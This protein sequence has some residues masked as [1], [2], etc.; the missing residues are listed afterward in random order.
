M[1]LSK[2]TRPSLCWEFTSLLPVR[3]RR[4]LK[5]PKREKDVTSGAGMG[6]G[7]LDSRVN[8]GQKRL[9]SVINWASGNTENQFHLFIYIFRASWG[10][11]WELSL[12]ELLDL[13]TWRDI[14]GRHRSLQRHRQ[15]G[16][17]RHPHEKPSHGSKLTPEG[18][19]KYS[20]GRQQHLQN[21]SK[22]P[23]S[24][25]PSPPRY[26]HDAKYNPWERDGINSW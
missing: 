16:A 5:G 22:S 25:C 15:E 6:S 13:W 9:Y 14:K 18:D 3:I 2:E 12:V 7:C 20:P 10:S 21:G 1:P 8:R 4:L 23:V 17:G 11:V 26:L 24:Q 19:G